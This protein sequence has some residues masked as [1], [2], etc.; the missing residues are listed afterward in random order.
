[1][2]IAYVPQADGSYCVYSKMTLNKNK[3]ATLGIEPGPK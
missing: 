2:N 3:T 1:M